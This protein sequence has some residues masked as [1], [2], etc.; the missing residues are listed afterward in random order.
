V[1]EACTIEPFVVLVADVDS[2]PAT[3]WIAVSIGVETS[4]PTT[5][6][7][8]PGYV[9]TTISVG[10]SI[11]GMSSC[12]R[13]VSARP[14]KIAATIVMRAMSARFRR[15]RTASFDTCASAGVEDAAARCPCCASGRRRYVNV[16][17][18]VSHEPS[19]ASAPDTAA[20]RPAT[21]R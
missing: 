18:S 16:S 21:V 7:D 14:P 2:S 9:E 15:L 10:N 8:A 20:R 19:R 5:S 1:K 4:L 3:P 12:L 17:G 13:L 6:G 11:D